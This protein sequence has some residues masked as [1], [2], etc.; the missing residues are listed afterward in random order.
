MT[1]D[2]LKTL[3]EAYRREQDQEA[4]DQIIEDLKARWA[5]MAPYQLDAER[6]RIRN[7]VRSPEIKAAFLEI[8]GGTFDGPTLRRPGSLKPQ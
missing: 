8:Y 6:T 7:E 1:D 5:A 3:A 4:Q 2:E